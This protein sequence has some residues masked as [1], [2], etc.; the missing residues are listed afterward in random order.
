MDL[1]V[2]VMIVGQDRILV[3]AM[4]A[5]LGAR[6]DIH[7]LSG[8]PPPPERGVDVV[9]I[10]SSLRRDDALA[11]TWR[12]G[13][14]LPGAKPIVFGID[15]EDDGVVDFIQ[16]GALGYVV[17]GT[18]AREL[19]E[20]IHD[21]HSG[22]SRCASHIASSVVERISRLATEREPPRESPPEPLTAREIEILRAVAAGLSNKE[23][24]KRLRISVSTVKNHVHN[25]LEKL[26][27]G[28][29]REAVKLAYRLGLLAEE[30]ERD[31]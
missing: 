1:L 24:G 11:A 26:G 2:T 15:R 12:I 5:W 6:A 28:H 7:V 3:Q 20:I 16:A 22:R 14:E 27:V 17:K 13:E 30:V 4:E 9:L 8:E 23:I 31:S 19:A 25:V 21:V 18:P 10:D 29:R